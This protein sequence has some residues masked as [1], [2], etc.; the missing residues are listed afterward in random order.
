MQPLWAPVLLL[1]LL[2]CARVAAPTRLLVSFNGYYSTR[3]HPRLLQLDA[4][5][6]AVN[7]SCVRI[8]V[9]DDA[10]LRPS[11]PSDF[12]VLSVSGA[13]RCSVLAI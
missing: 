6:Q 5:A 11:L 1:L 8:A 3:H 4:L 13:G 9:A 12:A 10:H 2:T 7:S